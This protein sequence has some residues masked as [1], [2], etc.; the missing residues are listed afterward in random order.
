M[1]ALSIDLSPREI[2]DR[3]EVAALA[4]PHRIGAEGLWP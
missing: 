4:R 3:F 2:E 1:K